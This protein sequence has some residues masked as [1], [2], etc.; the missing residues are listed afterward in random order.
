M[1]GPCSV[2]PVQLSRTTPATSA[3]CSTTPQASIGVCQT[4]VSL[5]GWLQDNALIGHAKA[6]GSNECGCHQ[7]LIGVH[8]AGHG[9]RRSSGVYCVAKRAA[10]EVNLK[11]LRAGLHACHIDVAIRTVRGYLVVASGQAHSCKANRHDLCWRSPQSGMAVRNCCMHKTLK[12][13]DSQRTNE[14]P[15]TAAF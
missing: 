4:K 3:F 8:G 11:W 10:S 5:F 2:I 9:I 12:R 15:A 6:F 13:R 14:V 7:A 1:A